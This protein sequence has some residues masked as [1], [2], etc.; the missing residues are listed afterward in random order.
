MYLPL[1]LSVQTERKIAEIDVAIDAFR[2]D[3]SQRVVEG[4]LENDI[5][6]ANGDPC[7][8][9]EEGLLRVRAAREGATSASVRGLRLAHR[10]DCPTAEI[11]GDYSTCPLV[12]HLENPFRLP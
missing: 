11:G 1:E 12:A 4:S 2:G 6:L 3:A 10:P 5:A 7:A 8:S 9:A